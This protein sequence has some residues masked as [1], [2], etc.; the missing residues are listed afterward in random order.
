[1]PR[2]EEDNE[3]EDEDENKDEDEDEGE[4]GHEGGRRRTWELMMMG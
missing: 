1:M 3:D 2:E 4:R